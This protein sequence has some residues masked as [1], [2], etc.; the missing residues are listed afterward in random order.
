MDQASHAM[1]LRRQS[2]SARAFD[3]N[4]AVGLNGGLGENA[5]QIDDRACSRDRTA[6]AVVVPYIRLDN[7]RCFGAAAILTR[8]GYR[9]AMRTAT[10]RSRSYV[11]K[12]RPMKPVPPN[13]VTQ[14]AISLSSTSYSGSNGKPAAAFG[15][16][17]QINVSKYLESPCDYH[18]LAVNLKC[19]NA[20][21]LPDLC[22]P[23]NPWKFYQPFTMGH[24]IAARWQR[25]VR[26]P[27]ASRSATTWWRIVDRLRG[28]RRLPNGE[29]LLCLTPR[30]L[31]T[32][33][34]GDYR[35]YYHTTRSSRRST[36]P[37]ITCSP[38]LIK[39]EGNPCWGYSRSRLRMKTRSYPA[40]VPRS[41]SS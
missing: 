21:Q 31:G 24:E 34:A 20:L 33:R 25:W 35:G 39:I 29:E 40:W 14:P 4:S 3:V 13:T 37:D 8:P 11:T 2:Y 9:T 1:A 41:V 16:I 12:W 27:Q 15:V 38:R 17:V 5:D 26:R 7:L 6:D 10:P 30:T 22:Y 28:M 32:R 18:T 36:P 23:I 19:F